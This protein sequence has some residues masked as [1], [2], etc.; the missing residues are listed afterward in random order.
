LSLIASKVPFAHIAH[1]IQPKPTPMI[2][3]RAGRVVITCGPSYEPIDQ[4]RRITNSSTGRLGVTLANHLAAA[5]WPVICLKG[6]GAVFREPLRSEVTEIPFST[7]SDLLDRLAAIPERETVHAVF[8]AAAL[9]D[10]RVKSAATAAGGATSAAK[11]S[12]R[13]GEL[14]LTLEPAPKVIGRLRPLFPTS[15]M[16]GW[17]YELEGGR[18]SVI[19][20]A[21]RQLAENETDACVVNG[22]AYGEG[23]GVVRARIEAVQHLE[24]L[25]SLA[26][27][28]AG[29]LECAELA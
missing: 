16:M 19:Q 12:S 24:G 4:V 22:G 5:G 26:E 18:D 7:N 10:F 25:P 9:C 28:L 23:F 27:W 8:H 29:W 2:P 11:I 14:S 21:R 15:R 6:D 3:L 13:E 1:D 17:K 20:K